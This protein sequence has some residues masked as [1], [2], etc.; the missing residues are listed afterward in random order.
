[1]SIGATIAISIHAPTRGATPTTTE[2]YSKVSISIHAPTRGATAD[3]GID[4]CQ[5][6]FQSTLLQE[7]R[8]S[9]S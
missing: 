2:E 7:E 1:M 6:I 8:L 9:R 5:A 3:A 4:S